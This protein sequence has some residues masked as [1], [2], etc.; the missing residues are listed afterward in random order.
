MAR[1]IARS[2]SADGLAG[3][4]AFVG[5][6]AAVSAGRVP[7]SLTEGVATAE[8]ADAPVDLGGAIENLWIPSADPTH[9]DADA[10][11]RV[12][13]G[14]PS[15]GGNQSGGATEVFS[16]PRPGHA[17]Q[18]AAGFGVDRAPRVRRSAALPRAGFGGVAATARMTPRITP[19]VRGVSAVPA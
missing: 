19:R 18:S 2:A 13:S 10:C 3:A 15:S 17:D 16:Y 7:T 1:R 5:V 6:G 12:A 4:V 9:A 8:P 11:G 14:C